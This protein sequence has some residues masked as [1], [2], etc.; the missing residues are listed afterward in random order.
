MEAIK[1]V[2]SPVSTTALKCI[3]CDEIISPESPLARTFTLKK[4]NQASKLHSSTRAIEVT[5]L[6]Q[7]ILLLHRHLKCLVKFGKYITVSHVWHPDVGAL[8]NEKGE[9]S[10][11]IDAVSDI[12]HEEPVHMFRGIATGLGNTEFELWHDYLSVPQWME[13]WK[14]KIIQAIP[15]I[16]Q[17]ST[18][19]VI[20]LADISIDSISAI[21]SEG[22]SQFEICKGV[23]NMCNAK[24]FSRVWTAMEFAKSKNIRGMVQGHN[25]IPDHQSYRSLVHEMDARWEQQVSL[26]GGPHPIEI[27]V[28][29]GYN[30]VPWQLGS[31]EEV[32]FRVGLNQRNGFANAYEFLALRGITKPRDFFH[33]ML[34]IV[35]VELTYPDLHPN[36][37]EALQQI[38]RACLVSG[39]L[40]V[41]L[42]MPG[43]SQAEADQ[44]VIQ[45]FGYRDMTTFAL[46]AEAEPPTYPDVCLLDPNVSV[47]KAENMGKVKYVRKEDWA[48]QGP[49]GAFSIILQLALECTGLMWTA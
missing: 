19:T 33:A 27:M 29:M 44:D 21:R 37:E 18:F 17:N 24:Y 20:H 14:G 36:N 11:S 26:V 5:A 3:E 30:L 49:W 25:L 40:S 6:S 45:R 32:R 22:S 34:S 1:N 13:D 2:W 4:Q 43:S 8:H 28:N 48:D 38:A 31:L 39:D 12:I 10:V 9:A 23:S 42:M 7:T 15:E 35:K 16:Y 47:F 46:G 41:L